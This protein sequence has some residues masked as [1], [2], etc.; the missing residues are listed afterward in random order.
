MQGSFTCPYC[1][2]KNACN[3]ESCSKHIKE[4]EYINKWTEDGEFLICGNRQKIYS[5]DQALDEEWEQIKN[6]KN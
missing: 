2:A 6:L 3:C 4:G 5:P 1:K